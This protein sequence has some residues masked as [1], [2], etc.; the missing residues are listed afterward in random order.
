M[1]NIRIADEARR[2]SKQLTQRVT[3]AVLDAGVGHGPRHFDLVPADHVYMVASQR[4]C[5]S[6]AC[7]MALDTGEAV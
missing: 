5:P 3:T 7:D 6:Q 2:H 1:D 4:L